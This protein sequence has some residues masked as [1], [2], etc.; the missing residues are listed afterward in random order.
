MKNLLRLFSLLLLFNFFSCGSFYNSNQ[1]QTKDGISGCPEG[2]ECYA[3]IIKNKSINIEK[4][5]SNNYKDILEHDNS[6]NVVR[7][8]YKQIGDQQ[9]TLDYEEN[10]Y[11]QI[12]LDL[13]EIMNV[14]EYLIK[15][16]MII[17]KS[18]QNCDTK[19][20]FEN[21]DSGYL[22]VSQFEN[23]YQIYF[24]INPSSDF[25]IN[26]VKTVIQADDYQYSF[27]E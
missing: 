9:T 3:E 22:Y 18:C 15:N 5:S 23:D 20:N 17:I 25:K 19:N 11:F 2:F 1:V 24:E 13:K 16:K 4:A 8:V 12:P 10:V 26:K 27:V 14:D 21:L 6:Y 7:Y